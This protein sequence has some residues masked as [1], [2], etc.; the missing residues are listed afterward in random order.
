M[1]YRKLPHGEE[2]ISV[3]G[4]GSSVVG[5]QPEKK[6]I[7]TVTYAL[8]HGVNYFDMAGGHASIF[9]AYGKA[10]QG[11]RNDVMLQVHFGANYVSGADVYKRQTHIRARTSLRMQKPSPDCTATNM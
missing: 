1:E 10:L 4:M 5:E 8:E 9:P 7:E 11:C 2:E 6:I 3:I